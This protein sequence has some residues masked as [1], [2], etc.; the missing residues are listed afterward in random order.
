[1]F[2]VKHRIKYFP[3][4]KKLLIYN[5]NQIYNVF[6]NLNKNRKIISFKIVEENEDL[7]L[8]TKIEF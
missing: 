6:L 5:E 2:H 4:N 3:G 1:M 7:T 8:I